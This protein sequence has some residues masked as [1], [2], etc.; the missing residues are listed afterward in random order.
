ME[1]QFEAVSREIGMGRSPG[2]V[3]VYVYQMD[4]DSREFYLT[5]IFESREA[6]VANAQSPE[7]NDR[8]MKLMAVLE[9]EPE[10]HD[11][12]IIYHT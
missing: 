10:W 3:A 9:S 12:E 7:Q 5:A 6:Y 11:G 2:Q 4:S 8:F 1:T